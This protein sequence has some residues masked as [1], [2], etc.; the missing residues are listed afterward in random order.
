[1]RRFIGRDQE[2]R[3]LRRALDEVRA[4]VGA[5]QPGRCVLM[6]G[7]RRVGKSTLV[8]EFLAREAVPHLFF[9]AAG[10]SAEDE[11]AE[12]LDAAA[13]S[14]LPDRSLF[15]EET[16]NQW[17]AAF[18]LLAE[19]LPDDAPSVVVIDEVPYLMERVEAFEGLLQRA[20]DRLLSRKPVLL[21]LVGSDLSMMEALNSYDRPFHQRGREMV[22]GPLTPADIGEMLDLEPAAAFDAALI[23]GGLPLICR[24]WQAGAS[25]WDFLEAAL[26]NPIS[27]LLV[28]A[29]RSLAA[30]FP[31][32]AMGRDV[33]R[34][35]GSGERTFTNI[36]RAAGG[37]AHSTLSRSADLLSDKRVVAAELPISLRPSKERRYRVADP[38]LRFW[39]A[40]LDPHMAEIERMRGD[41]TLARIREQWTSWRG[42]AVEPLVRESLARILPDRG[43]P[44]APAV[45]G[46]WTRSND[47]EVDLVGA[48]R[49]PV[50]KRLLF[51]GSVKWLETAPFDAHDLAALHK[52]RAVLTDEPVPL[53]A[54]SRSGVTCSG[55]QAAFGPEDLL[56][57]WRPR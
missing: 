39:L 57:A 31:P 14:S 50:A 19:I 49:Q 51:L 52:H 12:L 55:L 36:A 4:E 25:M 6:R 37:I 2:L 13:G 7:R 42:R 22:V 15:A 29:E 8:E 45:G 23:T 3:T 21:L 16:P 48:D 56:R 26:E 20:W 41:L 18:R 54:V 9:T 17:N 47:V 35:I 30:E 38:Y 43:L 28:S 53:V 24:E 32:Q 5:A 34:A 46:Y 10:G 44:A 33:L 40:F 11:L 1:M 27:A